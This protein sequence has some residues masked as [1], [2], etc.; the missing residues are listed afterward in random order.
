[1]DTQ[2]DRSGYAD[3]PEYIAKDSYSGKQSTTVRKGMRVT[4]WEAR[5]LAALAPGGVIFESF[6]HVNG[7][8]MFGR[9]RYVADAAGNLHCYDSDGA[10]KIIHPAAR[11][12]RI[13][14]R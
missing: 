6:G 3:M 10:R 11:K 2:V 1:M 8:E 7:R 14:T 5:E 13:I 12:L 4:I 9:T